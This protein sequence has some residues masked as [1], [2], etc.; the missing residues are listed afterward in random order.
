MILSDIS[1][2]RP[3]LMT[4]VIFVFIVLGV[5]SLGQLG[6]DLMPKMDL[7]YITVITVYPGAGPEEIETLINEPIEEEISS[8][9]GVK[10]SY[11]VA[12]EGVSAVI[13]EMQLGEDVDIASID[14]KD[15]LSTIRADLPDDIREPIIQKFEMGAQAIVS[16]SVTGDLPLQD[17]YEVVDNLIKPELL[18]I[19]GLASV[20]VI[21][22]K[23]REI[24]VVLSTELLRAYNLSPMQVVAA[25]GMENLTLPAGRIQRGRN[26]YTLR[27]DG[28]FVSVDDL[29]ATRISTPSGP[30][31]LDRVAKVV[32]SF[33]EMRELARYNS[34]ESIGLDLIKQTDAN[35]VQAADDILNQIELIKPRLPKGV[36]LEVATDRSQFIRDSVADV[37]GNLMLGILFTAIVLFVF[38]HSWRSTLIAA[39]AMP[40]SI[41]ST[42]TLLSAAG[43]TLN[44]MSLMGLAISVGILVVN[45]IVVLE[46]IERLEKEGY[47]MEEA[48]SKGTG[49]IALAVT[50]STLT[51]V[52]VF[53]PMAFM[54]GIIGPIF[55]QFGLTVA[56]AT[57]FSL[58]VSFTLT[59]MMA[60]RKLRKG[61]Y[62]SVGLILLAGVYVFLG[63]MMTLVF[64]LIVLFILAVQRIGWMDRFATWWDKWY[65][66]LE[67]DY[68]IGLEWA[69]GHRKLVMGAVTVL[70]IFGL[71]LFGLV[72]SEFFPN[73]D[74]REMSVSVEMPAGTRIEETNKVL[75]RIEEEI[76]QYPEVI[77]VYT[78]V[79]KSSTS[80]FGSSE[81]VQY[82]GIAVTLKP[83]EEG[84]YPPTSEIVKELRRK[85]ADIPAAKLTIAED[86][87]FGGGGGADIQ[88]ELQGFNMDDLVTASDSVVA[89]IKRTGR[90][91]NVKSDWVV[92]K[93]EIVVKPD[94]VRMSERGVSV[95]QV[96]MELR[97]MFEG[98]VATQYREAS[99]EYDVK[100]QLQE[101]DRNRIDRVGD[102][103]IATP[104]GFVP[105]KDI[106]D[107]SYATGP[108]QIS[109]KN[110]QRV[111]TVS[112]SAANTTTGELQQMIS[113]ELQLPSKP[114]S[115]TISDIF[116]G[117][118]TNAPLPSPVLPYGVTAY[119]AGMAEMMSETFTSLFQALVL[120]IILTYMLLAAIL[121]SYRFPIIIMMTLPLALIGVSLSLVISGMSIS[122]F[123]LM[124]II[125]LVGIVVN[126]GILLIDY[127]QQLRRSGRKLKDAILEACP[128]RLRPILMSNA[129]TALGMLP[130]AMGL[131][132]G[133]EFRAPMAIVAIGGLLVSTALTLFVIPVLFDTME[134]KGE[135]KKNGI[136][137]Y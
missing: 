67:N 69:L 17:L 84:N 51:N 30:I 72:G 29:M 15:K 45:A 100:V 34:K 55:R 65:K 1:I 60:S 28:E 114:I 137:G 82:G 24:Q 56:F 43:F 35:T 36:N 107:I 133:G 74:E 86:T 83:A 75:L 71:G 31:R 32:D 108:A 12:Q 2:K 63:T 37:Q 19:S 132:A 110:K 78:A 121:E 97:T 76:K 38:L 135:V 49:E 103:L 23:E 48:A 123:S 68:R 50:A 26:E 98:S 111:I 126:N 39:V 9:S 115:Q 117:K 47:S 124:A 6:I 44:V 136:A 20:D 66:E 120:A 52:V 54:Q 7:P 5:F 109:R 99:E 59:P 11:S 96:A 101:S 118:N 22:A 42:F 122:M 53:T 90:A 64:A 40:I 87:Q 88:V 119:F 131:G 105:L 125:M 61:I 57:V 80:G 77:S 113:N 94:R 116:T 128:I 79:G 85:L 4:M 102:L 104:M 91:V 21:G 14:V 112:C 27:L 3:V 18:K 62:V 25:I 127:T 33:A 106:A 16:L 58:L 134:K 92:G 8:I 10:N 70:F 93:P 81:G 41:I 73:Y 130:L 89:M 46:N 13:L 129:A 95:S